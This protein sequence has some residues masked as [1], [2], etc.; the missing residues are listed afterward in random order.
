MKNK[1]FLFAM[2]F[3]LSIT[4]LTYAQDMKPEAGKLYNEGNALLKDG[5]T[6]G[7]IEK[8]NAALQIE[9]DYRIYYQKGIALKKADKLEDA[10]VAFE[11]CIKLNKDFDGGLNALGGVYFSMGNYAAAIDNFNK[12]LN[13]N[14]S[15]SVKEKVKKNISLAYAKLGNEA[16]AG[17]SAEKG[18]EYL[19]KAVEN[20]NYDAAYLSLAKVYS[21]LGKWDESISAAENALKYRSKITKGGPYFYMGISYRGKGDIAKAKDMF[22][23]AAS[24]PTYKK[25]AEYELGVTK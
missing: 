23:Q 5:N 11:E 14:A 24:D 18:I 10:K 1:S 17:G 12:I 15:N 3:L 19:K 16:L 22:K 7:A 6:S 21:E 4:F 25:T 2:L 8:Y 13:S 9:K 20:D